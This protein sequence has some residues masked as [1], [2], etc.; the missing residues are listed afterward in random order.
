MSFETVVQ[1]GGA[2]SVA[3]FVLLIYIAFSAA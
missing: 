2:R 3:W 1:V